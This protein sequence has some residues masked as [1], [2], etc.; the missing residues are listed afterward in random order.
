MEPNAFNILR[1]RH[2]LSN[3][4]PKLDETGLDLIISSLTEH[5]PQMSTAEVVQ[6][7]E[8]LNQRTTFK[9]QKIPLARMEGWDF[10]KRGNLRHRSGKFFSIEGVRIQT[11]YGHVSQWSQP[12]IYQPEVGIL[13]ILCQKRDGILYFLMQAKI[14]PGNVNQIQLSPTVQ[15]T[16]SNY[17]QVHGGQRPPYLDYFIDL[18]SKKVIVDQLQSEQGARFLKKRNRNMIVEIPTDWEIQLQENFCWL[19]LG[20]IKK[21]M[22]HDNIVNMDARTVLSCTQLKVNNQVSTESLEPGL[23]QLGFSETESNILLSLLSEQKALHSYEGIISW[24]TMLKTFTELEVTRC[25]IDEVNDWRVDEWDIAHVDEKFFKVIGVSASIGN[26]EVASWCQPLIEQRQSGLIGFILKR[27]KGVYHL[28]VQAK[29]EVGNL[30]VFEMAPTVQCITGSYQEPEWQVPYLEYFS[31]TRNALCL[32]D[33]LQSEEGGRFYC[34]QNRNMVVEV[35]DDFPESVEPN[36]I[37]LTFQQVKEFVKF[38]NYFNIE[39]RSLLA[40][41]SVI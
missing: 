26:R 38:N 22:L 27:I 41:I 9:I 28:L 12:I 35:G 34:E 16:R 18:R 3:A 36:Y 14:E 7:I 5:N 8:D 20:Q 19:T 4:L 37:W 17:T 11:N 32:Y 21:L 33:Q 24:F 1:S 31:D 10:D 29:L 25:N 40:C 15:A 13:G 39:A 6:W 2:S 30:D 23:R